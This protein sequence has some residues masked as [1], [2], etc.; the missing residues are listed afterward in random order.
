MLNTIKSLEMCWLLLVLFDQI[1]RL[2]QYLAILWDKEVSIS[3]VNLKLLP[4]RER[5]VASPMN[6]SIAQKGRDNG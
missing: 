6:M 2:I 4:I 1:S 5:R 3:L